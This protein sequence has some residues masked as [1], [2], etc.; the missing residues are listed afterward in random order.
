MKLSV[1]LIGI[2][3]SVSALAQKYDYNWITGDPAGN[4]C[5]TFTDTSVGVQVQDRHIAMFTSQTTISDSNGSLIF[6]TNGEKIFNIQSNIM[7]NG[8]S[9]NFGAAVTDYYG[10]GYDAVEEVNALPTDTSGVWNLI[11]YYVAYTDTA[12]FLYPW[13]IRESK[14]DM[15]LDSGYGGVVFKNKILVQDTLGSYITSCQHAN[16]RDWWVLASKSSSNCFYTLLVQPD[17]VIQYPIQCLGNNYVS[18]DAGQAAFSPD[19]SKFAWEGSYGGI[20]IYD[21]D[22]CSGILSNPVHLPYY[23]SHAHEIQYGLAF[24]S[25]SRFL[26]VAQ[27]TYIFQFDLQDTDI[28]GSVDTVGYYVPPP[29]TNSFPGSY[30]ILQ[31]APDGKIY[32]NAGNT[33]KWM[34]VINEP[35]KKGDSCNFVNYGLTLPAENGIGIPSYPGNYRLGPLHGSPCDTIYK[36]D[37]TGRDTTGVGI[38]ALRE[39]TLKIYPNPATDY[40]IIDYGFTDWSMGTT[41][42]M[43][44]INAIGQIIYTQPLPAYSGFQKLDISKFASGLYNVAIKRK[45]ATVATAKLVKE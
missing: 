39:K 27:T 9:I 33:I 36:T 37:T 23:W 4:L 19:G 17:T 21:F 18:Q 22:R 32:V 20:N 15:R 41:V 28:L 34:H 11:H 2:L 12:P 3:V 25:N 29:D 42:S 35:D 7:P 10:E 8:D 45:G 13:Q 38:R 6:F 24:S 5:F 31:L 1:F 14:V 30:F 40:A 16:G 44:I 43:E 26:Y